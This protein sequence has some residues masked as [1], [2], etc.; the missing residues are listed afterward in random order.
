MRGESVKV[1]MKFFGGHRKL[2]GKDT[3]QLNVPSETTV[4]DLLNILIGHYPQLT[5]VLG[6]STVSVNH[7]QSKQDTILH[8][9]DEVA[10]FPHIGGG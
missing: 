3:L 7:H 10:L 6:F 5:E 9:D 1:T 4:S 2:I 8:E